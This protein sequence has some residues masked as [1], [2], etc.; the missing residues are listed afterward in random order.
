MAGLA[1]FPWWCVTGV[2]PTP[3]AATLAA[4]PPPSPSLR[5]RRRPAGPRITVAI[6]NSLTF[7]ENHTSSMA[8]Y[9]QK[10]SQQPHSN[11]HS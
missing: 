11:A 8:A 2:F 1:R 9:K 7:G 10:K 6:L 4:R 3:Q 5:K